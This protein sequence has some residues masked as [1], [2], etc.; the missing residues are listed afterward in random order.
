MNQDYS[1]IYFHFGLTSKNKPSLGWLVQA[2]KA[3]DR[4]Y[5]KNLKAL[6]LVHPTNFLKI[7]SQVCGLLST[8]FVYKVSHVSFVLL[9]EK[10]LRQ[11][12]QFL[13]WKLLVYIKD[14]IDF[15]ALLKFVT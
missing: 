6:Y 14:E 13:L 7:V 11:K 4:N 12:F 5:K 8:N 10:L 9:Y 1:L 3:F 2:Y 15:T